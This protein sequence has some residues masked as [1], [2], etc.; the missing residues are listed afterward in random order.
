MVWA[1]VVIAQIEAN[2][3]EGRSRFVI[4]DWRLKVEFDSLCDHF[5]TTH[6]LPVRVCRWAEPPIKDATETELDDFDKF[7]IKLDNSRGKHF[8]WAQ[9]DTWAAQNGWM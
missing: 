6:V 5:G 1:K 7:L 2:R 4:S 3:A 8:L 9:L